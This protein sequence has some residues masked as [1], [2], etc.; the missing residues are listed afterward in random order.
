M[1]M[2]DR[3]RSKS[4]L[5]HTIISK[6]CTVCGKRTPRFG[7]ASVWLN[8][9]VFFKAIQSITRDTVRRCSAK[10]RACGAPKKYLSIDVLDPWLWLFVE[11]QI[12]SR[13]R[14]VASFQTP[15]PEINKVKFIY[16][17]HQRGEY[18]PHPV[19]SRS[20]LVSQKLLAN[21]SYDNWKLQVF[22]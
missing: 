18:R 15:A 13:K 9:D 17:P 4:S 16:L 3:H 5:H 12:N 7:W 10:S 11:K 22:C 8:L 6:R 21:C 19:T 1:H 20:L 14:V 2:L